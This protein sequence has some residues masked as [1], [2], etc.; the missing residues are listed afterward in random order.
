MQASA[1]EQREKLMADVNRLQDREQKLRRIKDMQA[2]TLP[3]IGTLRGGLHGLMC[4]HR[5][6]SAII[7]TGCAGKT[8]G[9]TRPARA[10][11][12]G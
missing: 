11:A 4:V 3:Y 5:D 6:F 12:K 1:N 2:R 8:G 9:E 10:I 7:Y